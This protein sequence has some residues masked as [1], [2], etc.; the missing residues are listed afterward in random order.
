PH[1]KL[2]THGYSPAVLH[3]IVGTAGHVKSHKV[4]AQVLALVGEL[5]ISSRHVNRLTEEIGSEMALL[6]DQATA[7]Y[8]HHRRAQPTEPAPE[9]VAMALDGGRL[10][11]RATGQGVGVH[12]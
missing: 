3:K 1:L 11:T 2:D 8:V 6:R 9:V 5:V 7:D 10:M 12:E 4:A